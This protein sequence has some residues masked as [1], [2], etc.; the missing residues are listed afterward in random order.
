M[1]RSMLSGIS[2][3]A[4]PAILDCVTALTNIFF[5]AS[6]ASSAFPAVSSKSSN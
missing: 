2:P 1:S 5:T 6:V 4:L 3:A